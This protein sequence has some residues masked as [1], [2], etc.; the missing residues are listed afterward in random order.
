MGEFKQTNFKA[1]ARAPTKVT[2]DVLYWKKFGVP[3]IFKEF[4]G[5]D[6]IDFSPVEPFCF[7]VTCSVRVQLFNPVL[8]Q[9][10]RNFSRFGKAAHGATFRSDGHLLVVGDDDCNVKLFDVN[11]KSLLRVFKG[12]KGA[13]HR[14]F[15]T[16]DKTHIASFSDDKSVI[17]WDIPSEKPVLT[18]EDHTDYIRA[19]ATSPISPDLVLSG[20]YDQSVKLF[21]S[22]LGKATMAVDHGAPVESVLFL[23]T[24]GIFVS[25]GGTQVKVWDA[26][27]G[28]RLLAKLSQHHKTVTCLRLASNGKR[29]LSGSLDR[30]VKIYDVS[31]YHVVHTLDYRT[32]ILSLGVSEHDSTLAV[33]FTDGLISMVRR[34]TEAK[35]TKRE[36]KK[37]NFRYIPENF[38]PTAVDVF[39]AEEAGKLMARHDKLLRKFEYSKVLDSVMARYIVNRTPSVTV[40]VLQE[41]IRRKGL[42]GALAGRDHKFLMRFVKFIVRYMGD[43]RF[44]QVLMDTSN[45]M[46]D[47]YGDSI[48]QSPDMA[49]LLRKL[50][51]CLRDEEELTCRM[52]SLQ[53]AI[54]MFMASSSSVASDPP[55]LQDSDLSSQRTQPLI[56]V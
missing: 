11:T 1:Y 17:V 8:K 44:A 22:R 48:H 42:H 34:E 15:F 37:R 10:T 6:Y 25:A 19:G 43:Y 38:R 33:G 16:S 40:S 5:I 46:L 29:L 18:Y 52:L 50:Q 35:P 3:V 23:P 55:L 24:G 39:V 9:A 14:N 53:G 47:V 32:S 26:M 30:H 31:T 49:L 36:V 21:D 4:G 51:D 12:H 13:V 56:S 45:I 41:L 27:A 54:E 28:G 20:S 2:D 7:A